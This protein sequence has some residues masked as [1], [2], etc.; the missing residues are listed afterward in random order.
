MRHHMCARHLAI[1][2]TGLLYACGGGGGGGSGQITDS[3]SDGVADANDI[4][5]NGGGLISG[6]LDNTPIENSFATGDLN[7]FGSNTGG[8]VG[9]AQDK[10][11]IRD[12]YATVNAKGTFFIGDANNGSEVNRSFAA[13]MV[14]VATDVGGQVGYSKDA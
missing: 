11:I 6:A 8:L 9:L 1:M 13:N 12:S 7:G 3:D 5:A 4:D 14:S 10:T 2:L